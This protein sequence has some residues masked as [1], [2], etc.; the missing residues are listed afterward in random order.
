MN[1]EI[2]RTKHFPTPGQ[3]LRL[4][5]A[6]N[7]LDRVF[8]PFESVRIDGDDR[9]EQLVITKGNTSVCL[10]IRYCRVDGAWLEVTEKPNE[11]HP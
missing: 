9:T 10:D 3:E 2:T 7:L 5:E 4:R 6:V 8:G 11:S 1:I